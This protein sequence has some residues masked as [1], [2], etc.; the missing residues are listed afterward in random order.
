[1][2]V[3]HWKPFRDI[4]RWEPFHELEILQRE[5][6]RVFERMMPRGNGG[7]MAV[8][9][10]PSAEMYETPEEIR[11]K[12][13]VPGLEPKDLNVEVTEDEV[14]ISGERQS[15]TKTEEK[16]MIHSELRYGK[17]E[18]VI[19]LPTPIQMENVKSE[20]KNGVL[21]LTLPKL[22]EG[23]KRSVKVNLA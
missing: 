2:A 23:K 22:E 5:M 7:T 10:M 20:Y 16:G 19:P 15:E 17:F 13:E 8:P 12:I 14:S 11:L 9:F 18:R 21:Y 3:V 6:N 1:M 4:E